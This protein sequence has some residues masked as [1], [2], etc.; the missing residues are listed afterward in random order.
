MC[1]LNVRHVAAKIC[2][3]LADRGIPYVLHI[4]QSFTMGLPACV[5][6]LPSFHDPQDAVGLVAHEGTT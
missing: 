3:P 5:H 1:E 2:S 6:H 4:C